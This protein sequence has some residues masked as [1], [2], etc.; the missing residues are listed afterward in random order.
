MMMIL[1]SFIACL[2]INSKTAGM[3]DK[4]LHN[5]HLELSHPKA[6]LA[7]GIA[8]SIYMGNILWNNQSL[9]SNLSPFT[10]SEQDPLSMA[11]TARCLHLHPLSKN[12][13]GKS[14]DK[15]KVLQVQEVK[16]PLT[17]EELIQTLHSSITTTLFSPLSTLVVG[18]KETI[19]SVQLE[20]TNFRTSPI[21]PPNLLISMAQGRPLQNSSSIAHAH[22]TLLS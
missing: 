6:G 11:P 20:K 16:P 13:E 2:R 15:I 8:A 19:S 12:T 9:P 17:F 4:E 10:L 22:Q 14:L 7:H 18:M 21:S 5:Q 1:S 3:A